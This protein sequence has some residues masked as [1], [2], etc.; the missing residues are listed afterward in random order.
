[1]R[2]P[3]FNTP[4]VKNRTRGDFLKIGRPAGDAEDRRAAAPAG[5]LLNQMENRASER[6]DASEREL[7]NFDRLRWALGVAEHFHHL[8]M[9][10]K[11]YR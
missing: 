7:D 9:V 2:N 1:M 5:G 3:I 11:S 10:R 8:Y 6:A 4:G